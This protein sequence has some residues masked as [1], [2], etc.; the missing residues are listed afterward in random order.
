MAGYEGDAHHLVNHSAM[1]F[2]REG[3]M[4][5][6]DGTKF[7]LHHESEVMARRVLADIPLETMAMLSNPVNYVGHAS[8]KAREVA[9]A[10]RNYLQKQ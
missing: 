6:L 8:L 10:A 5:L 1:T 7:A 2:V 9:D 3:H 4:S